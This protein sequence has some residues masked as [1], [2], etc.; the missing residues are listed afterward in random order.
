MTDKQSKAR[1]YVLADLVDA[2]NE[3][4]DAMNLLT[5]ARYPVPAALTAHLQAAREQLAAALT[6]AKQGDA[7]RP[8]C[9]HQCPNHAHTCDRTPTHLSDHRDQQ[10][11]GTHTCSWPN[12][13]DHITIR[14]SGGSD[15]LVEVEGCEGADE[16]NC[17]GIGL[18]GWRGDLIGGTDTETLRIY[19]IYNGIWTFAATASDES[20]PMP[21][22]PI[23]ITD[24]PDV[25]HSAL[26]EIDAPAGT[27]L[28]NV[29]ALG[30]DR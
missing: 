13:P 24:H 26:V 21:D 1:E 19:A 25:G 29:T 4:D 17:W 15:D 5:E 30:G 7:Y 20:L 8:R 14:I 27:R 23:R 2:T 12:E 16:F 22:W 11:K 28:T 18:T 6:I 3:V 9:A 10:Q